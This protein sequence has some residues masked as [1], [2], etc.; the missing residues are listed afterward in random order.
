MFIIRLL[1][2]VL[3]LAVIIFIGVSMVYD[4]DNNSNVDKEIWDDLSVTTENNIMESDQDY[5][6]DSIEEAEEVAFTFQE[7]PQN[8]IEL[9]S[10]SSWNKKAP[11]ELEDLSYVRVKYWG[12]DDKTHIGELIVYSLLAE[13]VTEIFREL[14]AAKF[15]IEKIRL[16]DEYEADDNLSMAD[17][18]SSAF[19]FRN[20]D[21]KQGS[22]SNHSYGVAIDI[23]PIQNPYIRGDKVS[24]AE[25]T[26]YIN[27][28]NVKKGMI[29]KN[30]PCYEAFIKRGWTWGGEWKTLK[31]Y[32]HFE[33]DIFSFQ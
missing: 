29:I 33:K 8:I 16:I 19:C 9:V 12:F 1:R 7:L 14:Y 5:S 30:D 32:Q 6:K 28:K 24:P 27:R 26:E 25:A 4:Y 21:G 20:V 17:N 22:L 11:V 3:I 13:E 18:N 23:N 31:D 2:N 10:D 15:P